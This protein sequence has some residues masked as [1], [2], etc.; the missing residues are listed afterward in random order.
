MNSRRHLAAY[1]ALERW[2]D[3]FDGLGE[4]FADRVALDILWWG[5]SDEER[6]ALDERPQK[7]TP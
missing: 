6:A 5:L 1:V 2:M 3:E 7:E 4:P